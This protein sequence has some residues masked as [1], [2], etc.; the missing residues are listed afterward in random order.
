MENYINY[1]HRDQHLKHKQNVIL[2]DMNIK[3]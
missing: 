1:N 2:W 3:L